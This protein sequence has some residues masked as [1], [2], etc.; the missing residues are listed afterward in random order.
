MSQGGS[1][2][3]WW[4]LLLGFLVVALVTGGV[5]SGNHPTELQ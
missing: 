5:V 2:Q 1:H 3:R 4:L